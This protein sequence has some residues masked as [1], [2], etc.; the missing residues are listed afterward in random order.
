MSAGKESVAAFDNP[1]PAV[2]LSP[3]KS[4]RFI[5]VEMLLFITELMKPLRK[6]RSRPSA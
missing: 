6:G 4:I 1:Y 3:K 2:K 5:R